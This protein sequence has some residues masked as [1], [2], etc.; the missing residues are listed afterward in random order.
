MPDYEGT[1]EREIAYGS[2]PRYVLRLAL[3]DAN[4]IRR[5]LA[6]GDGVLPELPKGRLQNAKDCV[7]ARAL[8]NGWKAHVGSEETI[9]FHPF[10]G[11]TIDDVLKSVVAL[12]EL[13]WEEVEH[14]EQ[15]HRDA[16]PCECGNSEC[17][18]NGFMIQIPHTWAMMTFISGFDHGYFPELILADEG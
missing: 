10:E 14:W 9:M 3:D 15:G 4:E 17:D 12:R 2:D 11:K 7:L 18:E 16:P 1:N 6:I 5:A 8:S 13:G